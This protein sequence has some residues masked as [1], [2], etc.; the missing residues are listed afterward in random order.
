MLGC[1][2]E[3][4]NFLF[5]IIDKELEQSS[6]KQLFNFYYLQEI[7]YSQILLILFNSSSSIIKEVLI[8]S[9]T[10]SILSKLNNIT[11]ILLETSFNIFLVGVYLL[12]F[13]GI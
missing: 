10:P 9:T 8:L 3:N 11:I 2:I 13:Y 6:T 7:S 5:K 12:L 4:L 1:L